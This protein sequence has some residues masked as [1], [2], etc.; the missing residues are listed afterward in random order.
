MATRVHAAT[1]EVF[2]RFDVDTIDLDT[3]TFFVLQHFTLTPDN[4]HEVYCLTRDYIVENFAVSQGE[5]R[6]KQETNLRHTL[7]HYV[8]PKGETTP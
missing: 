7:V 2:D 5:M 8:K 4:F 6:R 3:L 1:V